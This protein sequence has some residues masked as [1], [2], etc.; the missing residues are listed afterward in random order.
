[1]K[2]KQA[3]ILASL[4][5]LS[6][7]ALSHTAEVTRESFCKTTGYDVYFLRVFGAD[8]GTPEIADRYV[9]VSRIKGGGYLVKIDDPLDQGG[10]NSG[11]CYCSDSKPSVLTCD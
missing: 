9:K 5:A 11:L 1:M 7:E 2:T 3:L 8:F 4:L 10:L 6:F